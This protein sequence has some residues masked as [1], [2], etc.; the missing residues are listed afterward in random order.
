M[1]PV[2]ISPTGWKQVSGE[3]EIAGASNHG[4]AVGDVDVHIARDFSSA[5]ADV[6]R[7]L[8]QGEELAN[9][10]QTCVVAVLGDRAVIG[11]INAA[12]VG[13]VPDGQLDDHECP[14]K[15]ILRVLPADLDQRVRVASADRCIRVISRVAVARTALGLVRREAVRPNIEHTCGHHQRDGW[16]DRH[17]ERSDDDG[18]A[19]VLRHPSIGFSRALNISQFESLIF[20]LKRGR[21]I[22]REQIESTHQ[23]A[24][25]GSEEKHR[26]ESDDEHS[27]TVAFPFISGP[28]CGVLTCVNSR[29][30]HGEGFR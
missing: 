2:P 14:V 15:V 24:R 7:V 1:K 29:G 22:I 19:I 16:Q 11:S 28:V 8:T 26:D 20:D 12:V 13:V 25:R 17:H 18:V 30:L 5:A 6:C 10:P 21:H 4:S 23:T 27:P 3:V 9:L